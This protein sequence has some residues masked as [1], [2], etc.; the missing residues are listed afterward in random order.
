MAEGSKVKLTCYLDG[1][2]PM[3][4]WFKD[5]QPVVY[6]PKCKQSNL[7][8]VCTL[9][10]P[11]AAE[12]DSAVYK[13]WAKNQSGEVSTS[14]KLQV[15]PNPGEADVPPTF[16]R[17]LKDA[18][19]SNIHEITLSCHVRG[20]P[21]PAIQWVKDGVN[22]EPSEKYQIID[23]EDGT[24]ELNISFASKSDLGKYVIQAENR[25][26]KIEISH[27]VQIQL[28]EPASPRPIFSATPSTPAEPDT[29]T[30]GDATPASSV[31][32]DASLPPKGRPKR[33]KKVEEVVSSGGGGRRYVEPPID[34]KTKL[35]F[36]AFLTDRTM[37]ENGKTKLSCYV[38]GPDPNVRWFKN[39]QPI[40]FSPNCKAS[41]RDGLITLE[42]LQLK[43]DDSGVYKVLCRNQSGEIS[44]EAR[45]TVYEIIQADTT[46]PLF[47][48]SIKGN[49]ICI[50]C[51]AV[52]MFVI[53]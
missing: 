8:G 9:E 29:P 14:A 34:P 43:T 15:F 30:A 42:L 24:C 17:A 35:H 25:A 44:C 31:G 37:A 46:P 13:C 22:I 26:G 49:I 40:V 12:A 39:D 41:L 23:R 48:N 2:D 52:F 27:L 20:L 10:F 3:V 7:N 4:K 28:K 53:S 11:T 16:T 18:Y 5:D 21:T 32:G 45:L 33:E 36:A 6:S 1:T 38:Q 51:F 47:T 50:R 19:A